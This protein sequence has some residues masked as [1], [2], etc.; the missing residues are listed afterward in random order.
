MISEI[1]VLRA[2]YRATLLESGRKVYPLV[3]KELLEEDNLKL[4]Q[5]PFHCRTFLEARSYVGRLND[6]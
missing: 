1:I 6:R 2:D 4:F 5:V 3:L